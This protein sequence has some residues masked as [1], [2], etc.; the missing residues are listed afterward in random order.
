MW[1]IGKLN[2]SFIAAMERILYLY[3]E[4][5]RNPDPDYPLVVFDE[6]PF[7]LL[8]QEEEPLPAKPGQPKREDHKYTRNGT[9]CLLVAYA[10]FLGKRFVWVSP[11]RRA[12]DYAYFIKW[13]L[14]QCLPEAKG[15]ILVQDNL[16]TH[17]V[18]SLYKTFSAPEAFA[19]DRKI[20]WHYTP[21]NASW[22][23]MAEI[24]IH[25]LT[26]QGL[27]NRRFDSMKAVTKQLDQLV[28]ERNEKAIKV[29]WRFSVEN[30][31]DKFERFYSKLNS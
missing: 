27:R 4:C 16:N 29:N 25:A 31:R 24:E 22:L 9:A 2:A 10:P 18:E 8:G 7:Q 23:N 21:V 6:K 28:K 15:I 1:C 3:E 26:V 5:G 13:L 17:C 19:L 14:E 12:Y 11:K 30:A 20:E